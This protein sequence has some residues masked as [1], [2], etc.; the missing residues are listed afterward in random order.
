M[1]VWR[2]EPALIAHL[3]LDRDLKVRALFLEP[4]VYVKADKIPSSEFSRWRMI[5]PGS[6]PYP[7]I[8]IVGRCDN[9]DVNGYVEAQIFCPGL[10][11]S[12]RLARR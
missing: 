11:R 5:A 1:I 7:V 3:S 4:F 2:S 10:V 9:V 6:S 8:R 12:I